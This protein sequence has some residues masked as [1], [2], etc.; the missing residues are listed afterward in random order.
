M[1]ERAKHWLALVQQHQAE[2]CTAKEFCRQQEVNY[3]TFMEWRRKL[4]Y[5]NARRVVAAEAAGGFVEVSVRE[6]PGASDSGV[7]LVAGRLQVQLSRGFDPETLRSALLV[8][9]EVG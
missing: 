4:G 6:V 8:L 7:Q 2:G 5:A 9:R 3:W 1:K